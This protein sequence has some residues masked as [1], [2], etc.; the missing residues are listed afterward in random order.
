MF[1]E[2][3]LTVTGKKVMEETGMSPSRELGAAINKMEVEN[4][5]KLF[6]GLE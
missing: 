1:L 2:F 3:E 4:F 6:K 5:L